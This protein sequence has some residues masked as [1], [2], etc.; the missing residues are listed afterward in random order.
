MEK[1]ARDTAVSRTVVNDFC[2]GRI[3][4]ER[5]HIARRIQYSTVTVPNKSSHCLDPFPGAH[6]RLSER[7][8]VSVAASLETLE[9][10]WMN[11]ESLIEIFQAVSL[12]L[13]P[14]Q[15]KNVLNGR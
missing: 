13:Q 12:I 7:I 8:N 3:Y 9:E 11:F 4:R 2:H 15:L 5:F 14:H 1:L 6:Q 10:K